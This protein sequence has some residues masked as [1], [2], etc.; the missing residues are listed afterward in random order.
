MK[1]AEALIDC[2]QGCDKFNTRVRHP[3]G[4]RLRLGKL[5]GNFGGLDHMLC[6]ASSQD[7]QNFGFF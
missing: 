6:L 3:W 1:W 2:F 4:L 5:M 7:Q